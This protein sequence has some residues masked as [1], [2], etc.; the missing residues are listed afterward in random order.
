MFDIIWR[1][2]PESNRGPRICNPLAFYVFQ[3]VTGIATPND[4]PPE[5]SFLDHSIFHVWKDTPEHLLDI[6]QTYLRALRILVERS[7]SL[8]WRAWKD[9]NP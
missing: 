8:V 1:R 7:A 9:S 2:R 3:W 4:T 5:N 6:R